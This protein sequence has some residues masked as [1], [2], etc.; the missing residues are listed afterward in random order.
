MGSEKQSILSR[1]SDEVIRLALSRTAVL[2]EQL[3]GV[4]Y[5]RG[6]TGYRYTDKLPA[7]VDIVVIGKE[8]YR[9]ENRSFPIQSWRELTKI[10]SLERLANETDIMTYHI[11]D[12][13]DGE[14]KVVIWSCPRELFTSRQLKPLLVIP[15][16]L[17]LIGAKPKQL[18]TLEREGQLFWFYDRQGQYLSAAKKGLIVNTDMFKASAGLSPDVKQV[19]V[20]D[21]NYLPTL[22]SR[23]LPLSLTHLLALKTNLRQLEPLDLR[24]YAKYCGLSAALLFSGYFSLTSL[25]LKLRLNSAVEA[26]QQTGDKT[27]QVFELKSELTAMEQRQAQLAGVSAVTGAPSVIW[28]L[29]SPLMKQGVK[30]NRLSYLPD[31]L[32]ILNGIADKDTEV[33][34]FLNSD[35][36]VSSPQ[37]RAATRTVKNKDHFSIS[38]QIKESN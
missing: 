29:L 16:T 9:E 1:A 31:G 33:L 18:V 6:K 7:S 13:I 23:L 35:P 32:F 27:Q 4:S 10:L 19:L 36:L 37:L 34:A 12:Y 21:S 28:R 30:V 22:F 8:H 20:D 25:Y 3:R 26:S 38:F 17:L 14:R 11:G 5:Q 2:T 15:E 24:Q